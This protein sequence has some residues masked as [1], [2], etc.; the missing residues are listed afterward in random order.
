MTARLI[1]IEHRAADGHLIAPALPLPPALPRFPSPEHA[2]IPTKLIRL[3]GELLLWRAAGYPKAPKSTRRARLA[4][5]R[6]C[7]YYNRA[8]N[9]FF[10]ECQAPGCGCTRAKLALGTSSCPLKPPKWGPTVP[11]GG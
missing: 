8:G 4:I 10:G 5:C 9:L 3:K 6:A 1:K 2:S 11:S 7:S